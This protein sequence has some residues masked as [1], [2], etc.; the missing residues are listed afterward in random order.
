V[1]IRGTIY[2]IY[3]QKSVG[4]VYSKKTR[5]FNTSN[6]T[7]GKTW[8]KSFSFPHVDGDAKFIDYVVEIKDGGK[9]LGV[10]GSSSRWSKLIKK[11]AKTKSTFGSNGSPK[12]VEKTSTEVKKADVNITRSILKDVQRKRALKQLMQY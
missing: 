7:D 5:S 11:I 1:G 9:S 10:H 4:G 2:A 6:V 12:S 8:K 3:Q